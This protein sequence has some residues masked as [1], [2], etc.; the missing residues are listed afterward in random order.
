M[1]MRKV[2]SGKHNNMTQNPRNG[3]PILIFRLRGITLMYTRIF[4]AVLMNMT[5]ITRMIGIMILR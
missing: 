4:R 1:I 3:S 2:T 5:Q